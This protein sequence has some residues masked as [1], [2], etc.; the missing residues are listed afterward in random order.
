MKRG[1]IPQLL[2][3]TM[4]LTRS[5]S[6]A[7]YHHVLHLS[8]WGPFKNF[9]SLFFFFL[10]IFYVVYLA[11]PGHSCSTY[12]LPSSLPHSRSLTVT[13]KLLVVACGI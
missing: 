4:E 9:L 3:R 6:S 13:C 12:D 2:P 11:A 10:N 1:H 8:V 7:E 5:E